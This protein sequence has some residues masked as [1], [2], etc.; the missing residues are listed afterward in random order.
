MHIHIEHGEAKAK[1]WLRP[2]HLASSY[3]MKPADLRRSKSIIQDNLTT[4]Q[5]K[6][7]EYFSPKR[8]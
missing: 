3:R 1:F 4:F 5:E 2:L 8:K 7:N 6:W